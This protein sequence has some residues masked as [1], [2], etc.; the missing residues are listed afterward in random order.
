M[1]WMERGL[2]PAGH[3]C[4]INIKFHI[5]PGRMHRRAHR[6]R[7]LSLPWL[8][9]YLAGRGAVCHALLREAL[10]AKSWL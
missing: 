1:I 2:R 5:P 8:A 10:T 3:D 6:F 7:G 4:E 9:G